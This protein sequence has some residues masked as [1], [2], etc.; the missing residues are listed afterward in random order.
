MQ[1]PSLTPGNHCL[2]PVALAGGQELC[3]HATQDRRIEFEGVL[4]HNLPRFRQMAMRH[5]HNPEDAED[6]VQDALL[7]AFKNLARFEGRARMSSWLMAIVIN[8]ARI[9]LRRRRPRHQILSLDQELQ[10]RHWTL[11]ELL[12]DPKPTAEQSLE[13]FELSELVVQL[14]QSLPLSQWTA[15]QVRHKDGLS[16]KQA[17]EVLGVP[18]GTLKAQLSRGRRRLARLLHNFVAAPQAVASRIG[19][20]NRAGSVS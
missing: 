8:S 7:S 10:V 9:Q 5:L 18:V 16:L 1:I 17:A 11:L 4:S 12:A 2:A 13:R 15:L 20:Q 3:S 19:L 14:A 6:A